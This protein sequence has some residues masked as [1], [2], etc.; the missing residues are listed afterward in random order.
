MTYENTVVVAID[1]KDPDVMMLRWAA[2]EAIARRNQLVIA[3]IC[4]WQE[5]QQAPRPMAAAEDRRHGIRVGA[6]RVVGTAL[7]IVRAEFPDLAVSGEIGTGSPTPALLRLSE[8]AAMLVVGARG[9]GGFPGLLMGSVSGQVAEHGFCPVAVVRPV[10]GS[11]TD[12]VVGIDGSPE[13]ARALKLALKRARS[14]GGNLIALH[15]YRL[16]PVAAAYAPNP[17]VD[18]TSFRQLAEDT[19]AAAL[20]TV[21]EDNPDVKIE[22]RV[23]HGPAAP[24]LLAA[25]EGA[26][27][28]VVGA[29]GLG[30]FAGMV[31][32]S[33]SQQVLRHAHCPVLVAH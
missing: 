28:L 21:E 11:A 6:D 13:S 23:E 10:S 4:E 3:H 16:P 12:V 29:R 1:E 27:A 22:R 18:P 15:A 5:G 30:G 31:A 17:G 19:L 2:A 14:T 8:E 33:V 7:D 24:V 32:G 25:A 26:A 9:I 20:G